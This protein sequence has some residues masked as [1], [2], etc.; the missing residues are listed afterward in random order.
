MHGQRSQTDIGLLQHRKWSSLW[1]VNSRKPLQ[2]IVTK[3]SI[4]DVVAALD[5]D[6]RS[7]NPFQPS[8]AC[9][10]HWKHQK[11]FRFSD[12]FRGYSI[13]TLG[14]NELIQ[15][16]WNQ[17]LDQSCWN[18]LKTLFNLCQCL[19]RNIASDHGRQWISNLNISS[20][21]LILTRVMDLGFI[22]K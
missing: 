19:S 2:T 1:R 12:V 4:L 6:L 14:W 15:T 7:I 22:W 11:T 3:S 18:F 13:A 9:Y 20:N 5:L 21:D 8:V 16:P 10:N 17:Y